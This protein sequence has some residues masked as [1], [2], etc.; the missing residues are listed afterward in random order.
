PIMQEL[1]RRGS[2][3]G[4]D[5][6]AAAGN[7][8]PDEPGVDRWAHDAALFGGVAPPGVPGARAGVLLGLGADGAVVRTRTVNPD[9]VAAGTEPA[10]AEALRAAVADAFPG[11]DLDFGDRAPGASHADGARRSTPAGDRLALMLLAAAAC[12]GVLEAL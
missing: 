8:P 7:A 6:A 11:A 2:G 12:L 1:V 5:A 10:D 9:A 3:L 4:V